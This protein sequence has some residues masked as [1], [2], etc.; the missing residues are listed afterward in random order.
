[1]YQK[2][3][4][5]EL[6]AVFAVYVLHFNFDTSLAIKRDL[7]SPSDLFSFVLGFVKKEIQCQ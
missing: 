3:A 1:M 5:S 4:K 6:S 2:I 7:V